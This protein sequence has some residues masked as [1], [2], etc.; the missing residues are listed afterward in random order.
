M[1]LDIKLVRVRKKHVVIDSKIED[2]YEKGTY[3]SECRNAWDL[4]AILNLSKN[5]KD[6][7]VCYRIIND[8]PIYRLCNCGVLTLEFLET[9]ESLDRD[10]FVYIIKCDW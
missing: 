8:L 4:L 3:V 1:G 5:E 7:A 10:K 2:L 6:N 9:Y